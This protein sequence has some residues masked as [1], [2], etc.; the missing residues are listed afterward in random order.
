MNSLKMLEYF[1][2]LRENF[3][4]IENFDADAYFGDTSNIPNTWKH[5]GGVVYDPKYKY[6]PDNIKEI[7]RELDGTFDPED[8]EKK[9]KKDDDE[10]DVESNKKETKKKS[11]KEDRDDNEDNEDDEDDCN[12]DIF[13]LKSKCHRS[14]KMSIWVLLGIGIIASLGFIVYIIYKLTNSSK[15]KEYSHGDV[16]EYENKGFVPAASAASAAPSTLST[17]SAPLASLASPRPDKKYTRFVD[18]DTSMTDTPK[19]FAER[20][21]GNKI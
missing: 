1:K 3:G 12:T 2:A 20:M 18:I 6:D 9:S 19:N 10:D 13:N 4:N 11:K 14:L 5:D 15:P 17:P 7:D 8:E 21:F 16:L